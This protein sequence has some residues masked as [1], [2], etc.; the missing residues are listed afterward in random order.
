VI[1]NDQ[2]FGEHDLLKNRC[3]SFNAIC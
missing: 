3:F 1:S 2:I